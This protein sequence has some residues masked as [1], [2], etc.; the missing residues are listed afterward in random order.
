MFI[1]PHK[2]EDVLCEGQQLVLELG[3]KSTMTSVIYS[4]YPQER[5][6]RI[7]A[8]STGGKIKLI[9]RKSKLEVSFCEEVGG[10]LSR[11]T[12]ASRLLG[13]K[14]ES[15]IFHTAII[16]HPELVTLV[17]RREYFRIQVD[18]AGVFRLA[19]DETAHPF[20]TKDF[21][22]SGALLVSDK[23]LAPGTVLHVRFDLVD[24]G[25]VRLKGA[26]A[27]VMGRDVQERWMLGIQYQDM[28]VAMER[29][30]MKFMFRCQREQLKRMMEDN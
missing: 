12:F 10:I 1:E 6:L 21:S 18:L 2:A 11:F 27:R 13:Y 25:A 16:T 17:E 30:L 14:K 3:D 24:K 5:R 4:V 7:A 15:E 28:D 23:Y 19:G 20:V 22:A 9:E 26:V 29:T 8:P